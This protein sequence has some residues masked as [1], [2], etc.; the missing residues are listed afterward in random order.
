MMSNSN[1]SSQFDLLV[2]RLRS[3]TKVV[4]FIPGSC[5]GSSGCCSHPRIDCHS[6]N[7]TGSG[8]DDTGN[9]TDIDVDENGTA[10]SD[11]EGNDGIDISEIRTRDFLTS[12]DDDDDDS[13]MRVLGDALH[14]QLQNVLSL[15][16]E[17]LSDYGKNHFEYDVPVVH[18]I[19]I[20]VPHRIP[21]VENYQS[22]FQYVANRINNP[23]LESIT[24][25]SVNSFI[26]IPNGL[27]LVPENNFASMLLDALHLQ[28]SNTI[29]NQPWSSGG[30]GLQ[31]LSIRDYF[32]A[33]VPQFATFI[34]H[35]NIPILEINRLA[36][37]GSDGENLFLVGY[38][39]SALDTIVD[40]FRDNITIQ[41][42]HV[43]IDEYALPCMTAVM[44]KLM[45][46]T[47]L[48][49]L[50]L[51][52]SLFDFVT[53]MDDNTLGIVDPCVQEFAQ[54]LAQYLTETRTLQHI[55]LID[56]EFIEPNILSSLLTAISSN[57]S[58]QVVTLLKCRF[59]EYNWKQIFAKQFQHLVHVRRFEINF[60]AQE[61]E[62][63]TIQDEQM[64]FFIHKVLPSNLF[65]QQ[66]CIIPKQL[67]DGTTAVMDDNDELFVLSYLRRNRGLQQFMRQY[68]K[69][70]M[71]TSTAGTTLATQENNDNDGST[72]YRNITEESDDSFNNIHELLHTTM[73]KRRRRDHQYHNVRRRQQQQRNANPENCLMT[74]MT[75]CPNNTND[76]FCSNSNSGRSNSNTEIPI[77][78]IP[79]ILSNHISTSHHPQYGRAIIYEM[80]LSM[81]FQ[82]HY[83][84]S[85]MNHNN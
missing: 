5:T 51:E 79:M 75:S 65:V 48:Q 74:E 28:Q 9:N 2:D 63:D 72:L 82:Y 21:N 7:N 16:E 71:L 35:M 20:F 52:W 13:T 38:R 81:N 37:F 64:K 41:E 6:R 77:I 70:M 55:E 54:I 84:G 67:Q 34:R 31:K 19:D 11:T 14:I 25:T 27:D 39:N 57:R 26:Y 58:I 44:K 36:F 53:L 32:I 47:T 24:I 43:N 78:L 61:E 18:H 23:F 66:L 12:D 85:M 4:Q 62:D 42:L 17:R 59:D 68:A 50:C 73:K 49:K 22:L 80:F 60:V 10:G 46:N 69:G 45:Y 76:V 29:Q 1:E 33:N 30:S 40:A 15:D 83:Y 8:N 56:F 3:T